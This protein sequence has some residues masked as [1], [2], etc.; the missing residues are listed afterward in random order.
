[1][2][3]AKL[4]VYGCEGAELK[5][6]KRLCAQQSV[7]LRQL[8]QEELSRPVGSFFGGGAEA[9]TGGGT[10]EGAMLV[11]GGF[12]RPQL[13]AF[14]SALRTADAAGGALKAVLTERN[15]AWTPGALYR[16]LAAEHLAME[17]PDAP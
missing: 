6:L 14:L 9:G 13:E 2:A 8:R 16:E 4:L 5:K 10:P 7:R 15:S 17:R 3:Q 1:M 12:T 11:F